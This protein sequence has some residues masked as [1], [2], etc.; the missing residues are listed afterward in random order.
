MKR[1]RKIKRKKK[2]KEIEMDDGVSS[3]KGPSPFA[4]AE[5]YEDLI[6]GAETS[7]LVSQLGKNTKKSMGFIYLS[8]MIKED[9]DDEYDDDTKSQRDQYPEAL[10]D[11]LNNINLKT[12][13]EELFRTFYLKDSER[14][15]KYVSALNKQDQNFLQE[16]LSSKK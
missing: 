15:K 13:I 16:I 14:L 3:R 7:R 4:D 1:K 2:G 12:H 9:D 5:D 11:P 8:D 6:N 10:D